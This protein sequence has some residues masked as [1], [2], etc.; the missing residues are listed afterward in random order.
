MLPNFLSAAQLSQSAHFALQLPYTLFG[1]G[2]TPNFVDEITVGIPTPESQKN[3]KRSWTQ[4]IPNSQL[5]VVPHPPEKPDDWTL[6]LYLT[7]SKLVYITGF[8]LLGTCLV[9]AVVVGVLQL[10]ERREDK[11]EKQQE[12]QR[13][14]FDAM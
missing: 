14:H 1:L 11:V 12:S 5:I 7:P 10:L 13:F 8:C 2:Q 6:K 9:C 4:I 3:R